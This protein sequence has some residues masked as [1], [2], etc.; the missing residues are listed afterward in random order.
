MQAVGSVCGEKI[1]FMIRSRTEGL[2]SNRGGGK[3]GQM[4]QSG[5]VENGLLL[6]DT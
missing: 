5:L 4:G 2:Q 1:A 3:S 6:M